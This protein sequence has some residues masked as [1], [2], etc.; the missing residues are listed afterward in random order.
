MMLSRQ[1]L[2]ICSRQRTYSHAR[3]GLPMTVWV[4]SR[5]NARHDAKVK[6]NLSHGNQMSPANAGLAAVRPR[7]RVIVG[8]L[9]ADDRPAV[10]EWV[11]LNTAPLVAYWEGRIDTVELGQ[12][13][14]QLPSSRRDASGG[15]WKPRSVRRHPR[16]TTS[17]NF[18]SRSAAA[19]GPASPICRRRGA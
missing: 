4:T 12:L 19:A 5:G 3:Q 2:M 1:R 6:V 14:K 11:S 17:P 8:R 9:S 7:P 16:W 15:P 18:P 13:L 10:F